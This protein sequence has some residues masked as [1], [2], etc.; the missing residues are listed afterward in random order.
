M[1]TVELTCDDEFDRAVREVWDRLAEAGLPSLT[2]NTHPTHRPHLTLATCDSFPAGARR[3]L[4]EA[5]SPP[6]LPLRVRLT[7]LLSFSA[8]SRRRVLVWG[9]VPTG[10]L[11]ALHRAV[12]DALEGAGERG[13]LL[14]P[15]RWMPHVGL[16]RRLE[17]EQVAAALLVLGR[18][19]D[20]TGSFDAA[21][22]YDTVS[23]TTDALGGTAW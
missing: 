23:H 22:S 3:R 19:P 7:G 4:D 1:R 17:P 18:L 16:T 14:A 21:R 13:P 6:N 8:R 10:E 2:L 9:V 15:G 11:L 5:L 12:W 20:L